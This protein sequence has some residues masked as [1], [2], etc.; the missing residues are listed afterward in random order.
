MEFGMKGMR[1]VV[2]LYPELYFLN[3]L[4]NHSSDC[5]K[6]DSINAD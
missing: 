4:K 5:S 6:R 1:M 3:W 2:E